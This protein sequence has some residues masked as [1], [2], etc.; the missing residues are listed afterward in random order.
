MFTNCRF[1]KM[2]ETFTF[3]IHALFRLRSFLPVTLISPFSCSQHNSSC[4]RSF[5]FSNFFPLPHYLVLFLHFL[6]F[7]FSVSS[8]ITSCSTSSSFTFSFSLSSCSS[9]HVYV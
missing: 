2:S 8:P 1:Q 3:I 4:S 9:F 7:S 5:L 6:P